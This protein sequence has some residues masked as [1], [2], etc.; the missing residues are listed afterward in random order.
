MQAIIEP[1][2]EIATA[3]TPL[4]PLPSLTLWT[5]WSVEASQTKTAGDL[6]T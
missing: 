6:P 4:A 5:F 3:D 1:S 2:S